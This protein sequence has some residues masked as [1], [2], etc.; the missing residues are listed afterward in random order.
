[1]LIRFLYCSLL[2]PLLTLLGPLQ[3]RCA[4]TP[5][6]VV[7]TVT[8]QLRW[9][10]QFQFAGYYAAI[11]KGFYAE[12]GL[13]VV[14]KELD[15][16]KG[17]IAPVLEG[18]AQYGVGDASLLKLRSEGQ[19]VVLLAQI[20]QH[21]PL[22]FIA[23]K[24]TGI[25]SPFEMAGKKVM[26]N[27]E[28]APLTALFSAVL[29][30]AIP[31]E[32]LPHSYDLQDFVTG[33]VDVI[34]GYLTDQPF[35]LKQ[36]EIEVNIID[37]RSY[38]IDFY[39]DNLFTTEAEIRTNPQR[40]KKMLRASLKGWQ[41]AL[42]HQDEI[43]ELILAKYNPA[44]DREKLSYEAQMTERMIL[45]E[46]IPLGKTDAK[47]YGRIAEVYARLGTTEYPGVPEGF[48]YQSLKKPPL[49]LTADERAWLQSHPVL[50]VATDSNWA[51]VEFRDEKGKFQGLSVDYLLQ[52]GALLGVQFE[53]AEDK[54]W[55]E[56]IDGLRVGDY[57]LASAMVKTP[58][59]Q[60]SLDFTDP[61][62][63][64]PIAIFTRNRVTYLGG[65]EQLAGKPVAVV[66]GYAIQ[67][68]LQANHPEIELVPTRNVPQA[69]ALLSRGEVFAFV[70]D[71]ATTGYY[72]GTAGLTPITFARE[73]PY[74]FELALATRKDE[75]LLA[76]IL[77][78]ALA[79]IPQVERKR[80]FQKW[81]TIQYEHRF[82]YSLLWKTGIPAGLL[83]GFISLWNRRLT[84][85]VKRRRE[86]EKSLS[87]SENRFRSLVEGTS[88]SYLMFSV[89]L[90]GTYRYVS[91]AAKKMLGTGSKDLIGTKWYDLNLTAESIERSHSAMQ[92][93]LRGE[94]LPGFE[95]V[96]LQADGSR[97]YREV[98]L[99]PV[100]DESGTVSGVEGISKDITARKQTEEILTAAR[101]AAEAANRAKS[102]F[103]A[104]MSHELRTPLTAIMGYSQLLQ[105]NEAL[106]QE[107]KSK[108]DT[109]NRSGKHLSELIN[110]VLEISRIESG[111]PEL[112]P[113]HFSLHRLLE[114]I[115][116]MFRLQVE[117]K[118]LELKF[119]REE[120]LPDRLVADEGKL[121]KVLID[122]LD[123]AVESTAT[124]TVSVTTAYQQ[125]AARQIGL[126]ISVQDSGFGIAP[127]QLEGLFQ[128][129]EQGTSGERNGGTGLGLVIARQYAR[130]M[131]GDLT[132]SS[133]RGAGSLFSFSCRAS[134]GQQAE[135]ATTK[136]SARLSAD[137]THLAGKTFLLVDGNKDVRE[138]LRQLF[139]QYGIHI[140]EVDNGEQAIALASAEQVDLVFM[141]IRMPEMDGCE[142]TRRLKSSAD[143]K[144]PILAMG[145]GSLAEDREEIMA[146]G[147]DDFIYKPI[148]VDQILERVA[149]LLRL[150][151]VEQALAEPDDSSSK[152]ALSKATLESL[153]PGLR[154][155]LQ[156]ALLSLSPA[157][158]EEVIARIA[159]YNPQTGEILHRLARDFR[160]DKLTEMLN[161]TQRQHGSP[162]D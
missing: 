55:P 157:T 16:Q 8:L 110:D 161:I 2:F 111:R 62:L 103:I 156:E 142:A 98:S 129:F 143:F 84:K 154:Q 73:T 152:T 86:V 77:E 96:R 151:L 42:Q 23:K 76:S 131:D 121:R 38:G 56:L 11:E 95:T 57:D 123:N 58:Q 45:P 115:E 5:S 78:K 105:R 31:V 136:P 120:Q 90:D 135:P 113:K 1:M 148:D 150:P 39:G 60:T 26:Y 144:A 13:N 34:S 4:L 63:S 22:I 7:E 79:A 153:P 149:L 12:E 107:L 159:A 118:G 117:K 36:Q 24:E 14:L 69:L 114:D 32:R 88:D 41:Y 37:P 126:E 51:P 87:K 134:L 59:R 43:S 71:L 104:N 145:S 124:G 19:P 18:E 28:D 33:K 125:L 20:F 85:E 116:A 75:P 35:T 21:S 61:Y 52:I 108:V 66:D 155:E 64:L 17:R 128:P 47:R 3:A 92:A 40:V 81:I 9:F 106:P 140:S 80:I 25:Y 49:V 72:I 99:R 74:K 160:Y 133:R 67:D 27:F 127:D 50:R 89:E 132:V 83:L 91:P 101:D 162:N 147:A 29:R 97:H 68:L 46:V 65:L 130:L 109:I 139:Q 53:F 138:L 70:G 137:L 15:P 44:L 48:L 82:D 158:I 30:D 141:A 10:H 6:P 94:S 146:A 112:S 122:L 100:F 119:E 54:S 102:T 93:C